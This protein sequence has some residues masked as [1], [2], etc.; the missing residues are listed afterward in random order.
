MDAKPTSIECIVCIIQ[1]DPEIDLAGV[2]HHFSIVVR[3]ATGLMNGDRNSIYTFERK[4]F[5]HAR[6]IHDRALMLCDVTRW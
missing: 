4:A 6:G 1:D 2:Y 3:V 5:E